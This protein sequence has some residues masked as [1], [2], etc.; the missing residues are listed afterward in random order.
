MKALLV[1]FS[2]LLILLLAR[3]WVGPGSYPER[4]R[5]EQRT[6]IQKI[7]NEKKQQQIDKIRAEL[8]DAESGKDAFEE[9]AR[10]ELG[11]IKKGETFFEVILQP[12]KEQPEK[13]AGKSDTNTQNTQKEKSRSNRDKKQRDNKMQKA[14][15]GK[16]ETK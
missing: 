2:I 5:T 11:M 12:E 15:S 13:K 3:L 1:I 7:E 9:R 16:T 6:T 10:S 8:E 14:N 4:W